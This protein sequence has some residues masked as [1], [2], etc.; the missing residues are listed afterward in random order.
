MWFDREFVEFFLSCEDVGAVLRS[1]AFLEVR[2]EGVRK[3]CYP[4][5]P[6]PVHQVFCHVSASLVQ[7]RIGVLRSLY[8]AVYVADIHYLSF[9]RRDLEFADAIRDVTEFCPLN[10]FRVVAGKTTCGSLPD[11]SALDVGDG[12]ASVY[13]SCATDALSVLCQLSW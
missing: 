11:L 9:V 1:D 3:F 5:V 2:Y 13:P 4:V 10:E 7:F 6:M 12:L 8:V